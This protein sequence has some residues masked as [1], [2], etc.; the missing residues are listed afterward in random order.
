MNEERQNVDATP[1]LTE[2]DIRPATLMADKESC[3]K[4]D[5]EFLLKHREQWV[6]VTCPSCSSGENVEYGAKDGFVF[7][8]CVQCETVYTNPRPSMALSHEFYAQSKNYAYW[9]KHIFPAT[10]NTRR[11][12]IFRPRANRVAAHCHRRGM[13]GGAIL[14]VGAAFGIFCEEIKSHGIFDQIIAVEPTPSLADTCRQRG[15]ETI[16]LPIEHI[17]QSEIADVIVSFEVIEHLF[18]PAEFMHQCVRLL[19]PGGILFLS[20]PNVKG[21]DVTLLREKSTTF[22]HQHVNYFHPQSLTALARSCGLLE[23]EVQTPGQLDAGIIR[24]LVESKD[25]DISQQPFLERIFVQEWDKLGDNF[26][27]FLA[28]NGLSSHMWLLGKKGHSQSL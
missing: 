6:S 28:D 16:E 13:T 1:L 26:Q 17:E 9:N 19:K 12:R 24:S 8:E 2:E 21:F 18:D 4:W 10:E 23:I 27:N 11:E 14:E 20:C 3:I 25:F 7:V 5:I 15:F 22:D